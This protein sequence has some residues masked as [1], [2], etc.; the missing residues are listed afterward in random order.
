M[1]D[2]LSGGTPPPDA[3][4]MATLKF[5]QISWEDHYFKPVAKSPAYN[6]RNQ[7]YQ[8]LERV[9]VTEY[10]ATARFWGLKTPN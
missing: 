5:N 6:P 10:V 1:P 9:Y 3:P 2:I 7:G 4:K 8:M